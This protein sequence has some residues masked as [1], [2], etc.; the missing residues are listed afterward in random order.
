MLALLMVFALGLVGTTEI[1]FTGTKKGGKRKCY[2]S[3]KIVELWYTDTACI[4]NIVWE[5]VCG[6]PKVSILSFDLVRDPITGLPL[7]YFYPVEFEGDSDEGALWTK[8]YT[9]ADGTKSYLETFVLRVRQGSDLEIALSNKELGGEFAFKARTEGGEFLAINFEGG[10]E[11][12]SITG[13]DNSVYCEFTYSG[14]VNCTRVKIDCEFAEKACEEFECPPD[15]D[16][17][18]VVEGEGDEGKRLANKEPEWLCPPGDY[19]MKPEFANLASVSIRKPVKPGSGYIGELTQMSRSK[20]LRMAGLGRLSF[21]AK[22]FIMPKSEMPKATPL[23]STKATKK[24][25]N[26]TT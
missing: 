9:Y 4:D 6:C 14:N 13:G 24:S 25:D 8:N 18:A 1:C 15:F 22:K 3:K 19:M 20:L 5:E 12:T 16:C 2:K 21:A 10:Q 17:D 7:N 23:A 11:L 26:K